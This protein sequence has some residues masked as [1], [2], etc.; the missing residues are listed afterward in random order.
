MKYIKKVSVFFFSVDDSG[1][2]KKED[3]IVSL[4]GGLHLDE[5]DDADAA[6]HR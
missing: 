4:C 2:R 3:I 1:L 5:G 6:D